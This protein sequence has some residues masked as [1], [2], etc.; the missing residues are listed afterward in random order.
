MLYAVHGLLPFP[1]QNPN[2][3]QQNIQNAIKQGKTIDW[4]LAVDS[5]FGQ[6]VAFFESLGDKCFSKSLLQPKELEN[7]ATTQILRIAIDS[8]AVDPF[9]VRG[10][11]TLEDLEVTVETIWRNG[12]LQAEIEDGCIRLK[13][14]TEIHRLWVH[15]YIVELYLPEANC[16]DIGFSNFFCCRNPLATRSSVFSSS[17]RLNLSRLC[18]L[19]SRQA[20]NQSI[21]LAGSQN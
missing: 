9:Q 12:W 17:Q 18:H 2:L 16:A 15:T 8:G 1:E 4:Q 11:E 19:P 21:G 6:P 7:A 13:F 10:S 14:P 5:L 3:N 20:S